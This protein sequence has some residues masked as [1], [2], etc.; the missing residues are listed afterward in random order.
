SSAQSAAESPLPEKLVVIHTNDAHGYLEPSDTC[1]GL[2]AVAQLK[3]D[4]IAKGYDVLLL[5][6]GDVLQGNML[7]GDNEGQDVPNFMNAAGY[8]AMALGNHDFDYGADV[9]QKRMEELEFPALCA[10]VVVD[11][12]GEPFTEASKVFTLSNGAKV[13]V[14]ALDT[15][16]TSTTSSPS[17]TKGLSFLSGE[18][19][20]KCAQD[21]IDGLRAEG[22]SVVIC[23]G[24]LGEATSCAPNRSS[25]VVANTTGLDVF[26]DAHDHEVENTTFADASGKQVLVVETGC[27][28]ANIG[29]L[30]WG[31]DGFTEDLVATGDY[32]GS[33]ED[34]SALVDAAEAEVD[35]EL[36]VKVGTTPFRLS[37]DRKPGVRDSETNLADFCTDAVLWL[38]SGH[39]ED[40]PDAALLN[41]G[42]LR[43][44]IEAGDV[45]LRNIRDVMPFDNQLCTVQ[46]TGAQLLE[47]IEA[48]T[49]DT[50]EE[51]GGFPQVS[52][53]Q[54][55]I[56]A[57]VPY[58]KGDLYLDSSYYAPA[59]PGAR[60]TITDVGGKGFD[61]QATYVIA[62][63]SFIAQGGDTYYCFAEA[64][65]DNYQTIGYSDYQAL[66]YYLQDELSGTVPETYAQPQGRVIEK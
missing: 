37:G 26:I 32:D 48:G 54:Y 42:G 30:T 18:D 14:F 36:D 31:D 52:G 28:L 56:D 66:Q 60:V 43:T 23:I 38:V 17:N 20:Y 64:A 10:N 3:A 33:D 25:D 50:P 39:S 16:S 8:D 61:P 62:T 5:S 1:L 15:P 2:A 9:L 29:V 63:I 57:S 12:T 53:I 46:V 41:G 13:G 27:Y 34:V 58:E 7:V 44:S 47:A 35:K 22:C 21:Q 55:S 11:A 24:H 49:Q 19:L 6:G 40:H 45:T 51:M 59:N 4:C 65:S